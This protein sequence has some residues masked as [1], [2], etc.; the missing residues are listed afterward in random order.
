MMPNRR[1]WVTVVLAL[2]AVPLVPWVVGSVVV[3][4]DALRPADFIYV[5]NGRLE[6]RA[7]EAARVYRA[8]YAPRILLALTQEMTP[9]RSNRPRMTLSE[10]MVR[11]L[12]E[13][14][15][16]D[17]AVAIV[18]YAGG[19]IDTRD[20]G[21]ALRE[22]LDR[23]P[24]RR[25][26]VVTS[27]YHTGRAR[28]TLRQELRGLDVDLVMAGAQHP[29]GVGATSWWR[30][31]DGVIRYAEEFVKQVGVIFGVTRT[32]TRADSNSGEAGR[33]HRDESRSS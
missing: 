22:Y 11:E 14:G 20:E 7:D 17:S 2:L 4:E 1:R 23:E 16:P 15:V 6:W 12:V 5:M 33:G 32:R 13:R 31:R 10:A 8:G 25:V 21:R 24:A 30:T 29:P 3:H 18:P 27:D 28:R 26:I 9:G 19:V